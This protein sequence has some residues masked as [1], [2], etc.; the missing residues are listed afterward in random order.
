MSQRFWLY[1]IGAV[2][3][4]LPL[5][6]IP[7]E[8]P[9]RMT[10]VEWALQLIDSSA[11]NAVNTENCDTLVFAPSMGLYR[12]CCQ[13]TLLNSSPPNAMR[14][15]LHM[16]NV[17]WVLF[18]GFVLTAVVFAMKY[19]R[20]LRHVKRGY[21]TEN[22]PALLAMLAYEKERLGITRTVVIT[23]HK[24]IRTPMTI[25]IT[26]PV[27]ILPQEIHAS[28]LLCLILRHELVHIKYKDT[29]RKYMLI[30]LR[31]VLWFNPF[32]HALSAQANKDFELRCDALTI[33]N[34]N[35]TTKKNYAH[36]LLSHATEGASHE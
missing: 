16:R 2:I 30:I 19:I 22:T 4:M 15:Y 23:R 11:L 10:D 29:L 13:A 35:N 25:G 12:P 18:I 21:I 27:I 31:C 9:E 6:L 1:V 20:F 7:M 17:L 24:F 36:L 26:Q 33:K 34:E 14:Y 3:F 32:V 28:D 8:A 5:F